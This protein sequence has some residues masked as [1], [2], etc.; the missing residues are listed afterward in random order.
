MFHKFKTLTI[1]LIIDCE[2]CKQYVYSRQT[3]TA[4]EMEQFR[5]RPQALREHKLE[6]AYDDLEH[7][8]CKPPENT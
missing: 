3:L 5:N 8:E 7:H 4:D 6:L 2:K 1:N